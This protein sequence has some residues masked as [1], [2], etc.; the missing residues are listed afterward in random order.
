MAFPIEGWKEACAVTIK[1]FDDSL[2]EIN[3]Y[4]ANNNFEQAL[5]QALSAM[6]LDEDGTNWQEIGK[7]DKIFSELQ[8][9]YNYMRPTCVFC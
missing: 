6:S 2:L 9:E 1:Q 3:I 4:G 8:K 5:E 7:K